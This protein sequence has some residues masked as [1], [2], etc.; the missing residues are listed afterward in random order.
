MSNYSIARAGWI[1]VGPTDEATS[2]QFVLTEREEPC[3]QCR[4]R[5]F[6]RGSEDEPCTR[7]FGEGVEPV[8]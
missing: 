6:E 1:D 7:C 5:G 2:F 8:N 3:R 4:G